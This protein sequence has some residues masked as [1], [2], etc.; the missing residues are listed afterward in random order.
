MQTMLLN[1]KPVDDQHFVAVEMES[2]PT[3]TSACSY[4]TALLYGR[5]D[6]SFRQL[7]A[8]SIKSI[9]NCPLPNQT[10]NAGL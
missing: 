6:L 4:F 1:S 5:V 2:D 8:A 9:L 7:T 10:I 3:E